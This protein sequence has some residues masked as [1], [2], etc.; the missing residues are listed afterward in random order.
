MTNVRRDPP[1]LARAL[2]EVRAAAGVEGAG[3][4]IG[5][6]RAGVGGIVGTAAS[7][8]AAMASANAFPVKSVPGSVAGPAAAAAA[9]LPRRM[10]WEDPAGEDPDIVLRDLLL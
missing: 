10:V 1:G 6:W 4:G 8:A 7:A 3:S 2:A 9:G 5:G